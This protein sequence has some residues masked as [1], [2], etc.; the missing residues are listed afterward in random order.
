[1]QGTRRRVL[2]TFAAS[3]FLAAMGAPPAIAE[4]DA[5]P[6]DGQPKPRDSATDLANIPVPP[7]PSEEETPGPPEAPPPTLDLGVDAV[8]GF[9][10]VPAVNRA[11]AT[12][13][14]SPGPVSKDDTRVVVDSYV[15][16]GGFRLIP[17]LR[18]GG[19]LPLAHAVFDPNGAR[20]DRT[21]FTLG[22][23]EFSAAV[24]TRIGGV[25]DLVPKVAVTV[26]TGAGE[27]IAPSSDVVPNDASDTAP[28]D[29]FSGLRAASASR[30]FEDTALFAS[31]RVG[32]V[33]QVAT[34]FRVARQRVEIAPFVKSH[35]MISLSSSAEQALALD[36]VGGLGVFYLFNEH[37]DLRARVGQRDG[38]RLR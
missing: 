15:L 21:I 14:G 28:R 17:G 7:P 11:A 3:A 2:T 30:G 38:R 6:R 1:M 18:L 20:P 5:A 32:I 31:R 12:T 33:P 13:Q 34:R 23:I 29:R 22:N 27:E 26:P 9:G 36:V 37:F 16:S 10:S 24:D 25:L 4:A 19:R 8:F 35:A